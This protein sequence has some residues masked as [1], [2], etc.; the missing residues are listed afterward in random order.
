VGSY[1][2]IIERYRGAVSVTG[3]TLTM[4]FVDDFEQDIETIARL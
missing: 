1:F 4:A 3:P 2:F